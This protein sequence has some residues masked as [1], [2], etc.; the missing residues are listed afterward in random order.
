MF[1]RMLQ[2]ISMLFRSTAIFRR[3]QN[4]LV[5]SN[6]RRFNRRHNQL[7]RGAARRLA[8]ASNASASAIIEAAPIA[9]RAIAEEIGI[10][11]SQTETRI[12]ASNGLSSNF[13]CP[14]NPSI[15]T[16]QLHAIIQ[17]VVSAINNPIAAPRSPNLE[18]PNGSA[19]AA[20][21]APNAAA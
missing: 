19:T 11:Q 16:P 5:A 8:S 10:D 14:F 3:I 12:N 7:I 15:R 2:G 6:A 20:T 13:A 9:A 17:T 21:T 18:Y 1:D 4:H